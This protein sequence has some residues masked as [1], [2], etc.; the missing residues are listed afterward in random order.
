MIARFKSFVE[1]NSLFVKTDRI[2]LAISGGIDSIVM[3]HLFHKTGFSF[4]IAHCNFALR[5]KESDAEEKFVEKLAKGFKVPFF[6]KRFKTSVYATEHKISVQMAARELRYSW[7]EEVRSQEGFDFI[8][9]AHH[10]DDQVETFLINLIRGTGISGLHG[11]LP[12]QKYLVR[13]MLYVFRSDIAD[14]AETNH[15]SFCEDSSN[16]E[17][18]YTRN[19]IRLKIIPLLEEINP[20]FRKALCSEIA[21]LKDWEAIGRKS[22]EGEIPKFSKVLKDKTIV[23]LK[24]LKQNPS[25]ELYAWELLSGYGFNASSVNDILATR[26]ESSGKTFLSLTHRAVMDRESL[27]IQK[28][29]QKQ[30]EQGRMISEQRKNISWPVKLSF[31]VAAFKPGVIIPT[32]K[33]FASLDF[34]K[35]SFP[36]ELRKWKPGDS[37]H[38]FGMK[39]KKKISDFLIDEKVSIPDKENTWVLCSSGKI[40]WVVGRRIDHRF[41]I[42]S[43]TKRIFRVTFLDSGVAG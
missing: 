11:I 24:S 31:S 23:D 20:D 36:L 25:H 1:K 3:T 10:L 42:T 43:G 35:L 7:F 37:F 41:R 38:P 9:T 12:K 18:K 2:L 39:G 22:L 8:A 19:K 27:I 28:I 5:G 15:I 26:G 32:E 29:Q 13:P 14:Y 4:G 6:V 17:D 33:E 40:A 16:F 34:D 30:K 21:I